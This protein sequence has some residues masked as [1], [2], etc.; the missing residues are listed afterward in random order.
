[1]VNYVFIIFARG[2]EVIPSPELTNTKTGLGTVS[3]D[4]NPS[5]Q[6]VKAGC[7]PMVRPCLQNSDVK[8]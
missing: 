8:L 7:D 3:D 5:T 6:E 4:C 2:P 1:M